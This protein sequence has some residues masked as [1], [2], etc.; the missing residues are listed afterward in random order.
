MMAKPR[1]FFVALLKTY[2]V[3]LLLSFT[4]SAAE[5]R[6]KKDE[7]KTEVDFK[8]EDWKGP[9]KDF[10]VV[11]GRIVGEWWQGGGLGVVY[12][13]GPHAQKME[14][15]E[16]V[17]RKIAARLKRPYQEI[18]K[19][20]LQ[21]SAEDENGIV[22]YPDGTARVQL[23]IMPGGN[24][25]LTVCDIANMAP[26][27]T[28]Q[29]KIAEMRKIPQAAFR[30][31]MN[32]VGVCGGC[33][34]GTSGVSKPGYISY[35]WGFWPGKFADLGPGRREPFPDVVLDPSLKDHF[36]YKATDNG[37]LR[38]MFFNGGPLQLE[39]DVPDTEYIG[40]YEGGNMPEIIGTWFCIAYRPKDNGLSGRCVIATG[41]PEAKHERFLEAMCDYALMHDYEV[42]RAALKLDEKTTAVVGDNQIHYY[43]LADVPPGKKLTISLTG[44]TENCD[45]YV[46]F[47]L[48]PTFNKK[49]AASRKAKTADE[50][51]VIASTKAGEYWIGVHGHHAKLNGAQYELLAK[52]E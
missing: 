13:T 9:E 8:L 3:L 2:L 15:F 10:K 23:F 19:E 42:P 44:L 22:A 50:T 26:N 32:Y 37:R 39:S 40:K 51:A 46:R 24:G 29:G 47:G 21:T 12:F 34:I 17:G 14:A 41:H 18:H 48:P 27:T 52:L 25:G 5:K 35:S 1:Q 28:D 45:L 7:K 30:S 6:G 36:L 38:N 16:R 31:G 43:C 11:N 4:L 20:H 49:D 33:F